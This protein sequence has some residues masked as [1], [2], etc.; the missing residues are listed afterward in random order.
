[1]ITWQEILCNYKE[2]EIPDEHLAN[3]KKLHEAVNKLRLAFGKSLLVSNCYRSLDHH[4]LI[5]KNMGI[6]DKKKIP[7]KSKHLQGLAVDLAGPNTAAF[8]KFILANLKLVEELGLYFEDFSVTKNWV[9]AQLIA[10]KSGKRF[11][12]P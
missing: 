9:H 2:S 8:K 5:Y 12:M 6:T 4:L 1:M 7:M 10:P 3:M 11:F